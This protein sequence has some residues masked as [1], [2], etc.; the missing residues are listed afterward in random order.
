MENKKAVIWYISHYIAPP[1]FDTHSRAKKFS[2]YLTLRGYDVTIFSSSFLHNKNINL[3]TGKTLYIEKTYDK[4]KFVHIKSKE[5]RNNGFFRFFSLFQ[6]SIR[7][8]FLRNK[9]PKPDIIIHTAQVPFQNLI[10]RLAHK[11]NVKYIAEILD[12]WPES[13]V[14][15][16]LISRNNPLLSLMYK[17]EKNLYREAYKI[18]FSMEGGRDYIIDKKWD[19]KNGGPIN[20]DKVHYINNGVD[21]KE[22]EEN[23]RKYQLNDEDL[24]DSDTFKVIYLGSIR[25]A[26]NLKQLIDA[27]LLLKSYKNIKFLIYGD[28]NERNNLERYCSENSISNIIFK[29][30]WIELKYVPYV[31]SKS[32]LN[33]INY[34]PSSILKYGGSQGKLFQYL[35]SGRPICSNIKMGYCLISKYNL[36]IADDFN[37]PQ[38]YANAI[39]KISSLSKNEYNEM[40]ARSEKVAKEFDYKI[41]AEKLIETF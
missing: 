33:I 36:G 4:Q 5:Y 31:V 8:Y 15:Y 22:F 30:K 40:C 13:F 6:F 14:A 35:A 39:L 41:L 3:I 2:E 16:K 10:I 1:E 19:I 38:E 32:S 23:R 12:L 37:S 27:A 18:I 17:C 9:F 20:L 25:L 26:N 29:Q 21:I 28:G 7:L 24:N 34:M 11:L